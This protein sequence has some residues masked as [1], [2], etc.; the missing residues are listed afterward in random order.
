MRQSEGTTTIN[1][2]AHISSLEK[3]RA[4]ASK[5]HGSCLIRKLRSFYFTV[6]KRSATK[7]QLTM[8]QKAA[9]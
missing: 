8:F 7:S 2:L 1:T 6:R 4:V 3:Q 9:T 5:R